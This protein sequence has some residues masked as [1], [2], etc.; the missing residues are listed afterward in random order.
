MPLV[1]DNTNVTKA[2]REKYIHLLRPHKYAIKCYSFKVDVSR[3][4][5]WNSNRTGGDL[6]PK[7][8][9][10]D[11]YKR[12]EIPE[13]SEGFDEMYLVDFIDGKHIVKV[14]EDEV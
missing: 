10:L 6:I 5:A 14:W 4:L 9:I 7:V 2:V 1:I 12:L 11:A 8:G 13:R 3:S